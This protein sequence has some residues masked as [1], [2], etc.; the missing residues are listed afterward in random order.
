MKRP[1]APVSP[2]PSDRI[3]SQPVR[4]HKDNSASEPVCK[5]TAKPPELNTQDA[6]QDPAACLQQKF[7]IA[8]S[9]V[10]N[11]EGRLQG[12][13]ENSCQN[14]SKIWTAIP[15]KFKVARPKK[16]HG[17]RRQ[18]NNLYRQLNNYENKMLPSTKTFLQAMRG[19][20][21]EHAA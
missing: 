14:A 19:R 15:N 4:P 18:E 16:L 13:L 2:E 1:A 3:A 9:N 7:I 5:S 10:E 20:T 21:Q 8:T 11:D 6:I 17:E 12:S